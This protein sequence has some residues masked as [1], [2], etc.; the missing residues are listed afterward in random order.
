METYAGKMKLLVD[1]KYYKN[2]PSWSNY[3]I[4]L[5]IKK[6]HNLNVYVSLV[7]STRDIKLVIESS[8]I[9]KKPN[10][11]NDEVQFYSSTLLW[12]NKPT[13][14]TIFIPEVNDYIEILNK[15]KDVLLTIKF[16][17]YLGYF[18]KE[19]S[20]NTGDFWFE[21]IG[22]QPMIEYKFGKCCV[23]YVSTISNTFNC[24]KKGYL[25][26]ICW[27]KIPFINCCETCNIDDDSNCDDACIKNRPCPLC[28]NCLNTGDEL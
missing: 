15:L 12:F 14:D 17:K 11:M 8:T 16:N 23:C 6:F 22:E 18:E 28:R 3:S 5:P 7:F 27:D 20:Y 13:T 10:D 9:E 1:L 24:C 2:T 4:I 19:V 25:C 21:I 26:Y